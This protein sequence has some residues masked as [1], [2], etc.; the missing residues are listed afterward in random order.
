MKAEGANGGACPPPGQLKAGMTI[1]E[2][3][4]DFVPLDKS[5]LLQRALLLKDCASS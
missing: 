4:L 1:R 5:C 2:D 3:M